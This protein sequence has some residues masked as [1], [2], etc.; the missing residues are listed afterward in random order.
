MSATES[1]AGGHGATK[2]AKFVDATGFYKCDAEKC[3]VT[4]YP[5]IGPAIFTSVLIGVIV[6]FVWFLKA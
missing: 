6:F 4:K 1:S 2:N 5:W 3:E